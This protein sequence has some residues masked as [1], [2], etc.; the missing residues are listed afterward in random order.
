MFSQQNPSSNQSAC[1]GQRSGQSSD[2]CLPLPA[3]LPLRHFSGA[4]GPAEPRQQQP[5]SE[6]RRLK[7]AIRCDRR[8]PNLGGGLGP[9]G[10][11][12]A[13]ARAS[14]LSRSQ[15][16]SLPARAHQASLMSWRACTSW[17]TRWAHTCAGAQVTFLQ[18]CPGCYTLWSHSQGES[19]QRCL[20]GAGHL[21]SLRAQAA[22]E[23]P[24]PRS[25]WRQCAHNHAFLGVSAPVGEELREQWHLAAALTAPHLAQWTAQRATGFTSSSLRDRSG[26]QGLPQLHSCEARAR[27][28]PRRHLA[29]E[30]REG[31][32]WEDQVGGGGQDEGPVHRGSQVSW[33]SSPRRAS[34]SKVL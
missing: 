10:P 33:S 31:G 30:L 15:S 2:L 23:L 3:T 6:E 5:M 29:S 25:H 16:W 20:L 22:P 26:S 7:T 9:P 27:W 17:T 24:P 28:K 4:Q 13:G 19:K 18:R 11:G 12:S 14:P 8:Y 32:L 21:L 34:S 1:Q